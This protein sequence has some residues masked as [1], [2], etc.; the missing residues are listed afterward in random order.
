MRKLHN[1]RAVREKRAGVERVSPTNSIVLLGN[2]TAHV[3][4]Y[5][6][7]LEGSD[8]CSS[9]KSQDIFGIF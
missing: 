3:G 4:N 5:G 9:I 2:F 6:N 1:I 7:T 8:C